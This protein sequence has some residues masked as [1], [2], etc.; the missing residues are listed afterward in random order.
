MVSALKRF[1][2]VKEPE[3][4][5]P[6]EI[7]M[8]DFGAMLADSADDLPLPALPEGHD[9]LLSGEPEIDGLDEMPVPKLNGGLRQKDLRVVAVRAG[10][11][12][13]HVPRETLV[14]FMAQAEMEQNFTFNTAPNE[15]RNYLNAM[16]CVLVRARGRKRNE[17]KRLNFFR[18][19]VVQ[20]TPKGT[21]DEVTIVRT[22]REQKAAASVYDALDGML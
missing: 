22:E 7:D 1:G 13:D 17:G 6:D 2:V 15:A 16:R 5:K 18:L 9:D 11:V 21:H 4:Q 8:S 10:G 14:R 12:Y 19:L 20:I 3:P